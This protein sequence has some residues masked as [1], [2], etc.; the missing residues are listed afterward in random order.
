VGF[1]RSAASR[2]ALDRAADLGRRLGATLYVVHAVDLSDYPVDP[3]ADD[4]EKAAAAALEEERA[5]AAVALAAYPGR[6]EYVARRSR[7]AEALVQ[8]ADEV[9][10]LM[11]VLGVRAHGWWHLFERLGGPS[12]SHH[13]VGHCRRPVLI[14]GHPVDGAHLEG[15]QP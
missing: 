13:L 14:V 3:D 15:G 4:W 5:A 2:E 8:V 10:A 11:I 7:P 6:W 1:D 12:V 9:D